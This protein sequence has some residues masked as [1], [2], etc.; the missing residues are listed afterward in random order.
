METTFTVHVDTD[1]LLCEIKEK[2]AEP[3]QIKLT[4]DSLESLAEQIGEALSDY[5]QGF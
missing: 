3:V 1:K 2:Q 5:I 4:Y